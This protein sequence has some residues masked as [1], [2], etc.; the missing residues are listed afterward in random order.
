MHKIKLDF[1]WYVIL[2]CAAF[3]ALNIFLSTGI[4]DLNDGINHYLIAR[5]APMHPEMYLNHWGKPLFTMLS[6]PFAQFGYKGIMVFNTLLFVGTA[7]M[8]V[9]TIK[10]FD[11]S[12]AWAAPILLAFSPVYFHVTMSGLTEV[13]FAFIVVAG[14]YFLSKGKFTW[15]ALILTWLPFARSEAYFITPLFGLAFLL[16]KEWLAVLALFVGPLVLSMAAYFSFG[17]FWWMITHNPYTGAADIYGHGLFSHF[18]DHAN[19]IFGWVVFVLAI[20]GMIFSFA[21]IK[22]V[23]KS[24]E[25]LVLIISSFSFLF[26]FLAHSIFWWKGLYGSLGLIRVMATISP[27]AVLLSLFAFDK[28]MSYLHERIGGILIVGVSIYTIINLFSFE[29]FNKEPNDY[30]KLVQE[31]S[32]WHKNSEHANNPNIWFHYPPIGVYLDID[33][34]EE[35]DSRPLWF[36][37]P[38]LPSNAIREGGLI[39]YDGARAPNEGKTSKEMLFADRHLKLI[40]Q[41]QPDF[42]LREMNNVKFEFLVFEKQTDCLNDT[43]A[44]ADFNVNRPILEKRLERIMTDE[45][46]RKYFR[47]Q[48]MTSHIEVYAFWEKDRTCWEAENYQFTVEADK[49]LKMLFQIHYK[50]GRFESFPISEDGKFN[51]PKK[52]DDVVKYV[53]RIATENSEEPTKV[54]GWRLL[55]VHTTNPE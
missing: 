48:T 52:S 22:Q 6:S 53:M 33:N 55:K 47:M 7:R 46:G 20:L 41:V 19:A 28:L 18:I 11:I 25:V 44:L 31:L 21:S 3:Y 4:Y 27:L 12:Y 17:D 29:V 35:N 23:L 5:Y 24:N 32:V 43:L 45:N 49:P 15:A 2:A 1:E 40:K 8:L 37:N 51:T 9:S 42:D 34:F 13:L 26:V 54:Y 39:I 14:L 50:D 36:L 16:K 30:E 38:I 10:R